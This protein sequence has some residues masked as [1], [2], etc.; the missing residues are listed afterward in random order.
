MPESSAAAT[1]MSDGST[2][3][4]IAI[5]ATNL[6]RVLVPPWYP[7]PWTVRGLKGEKGP[8]PGPFPIAG[9]G[10]EPATFGL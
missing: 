3:D 2:V 5:T 7:G 10:F 9:A 4:A 6:R 8:E 1:G